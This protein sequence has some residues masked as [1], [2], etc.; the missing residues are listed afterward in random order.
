MSPAPYHQLWGRRV[1]EILP[2][3]YQT[4][5]T[6]PMRSNKQAPATTVC[7]KH[8]TQNLPRAPRRLGACRPQ[9]ADCRP[10]RT[11]RRRRSS[12]SMPVA[13]APHS[14]E[15]VRR[16]HIV[17]TPGFPSRGRSASGK[18][19]QRSFQSAPPSNPRFD[20]GWPVGCV[21]GGVLSVGRILNRL[22]GGFHGISSVDRLG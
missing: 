21:S 11:S 4:N 8:S 16:R 9:C 14:T 13:R 10:A 15:R 18:R 5:F 1:R 17:Q 6:L 22:F 20:R 12:R 7:P 2:P 3:T 19:P